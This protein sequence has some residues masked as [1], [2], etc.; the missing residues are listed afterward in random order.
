MQTKNGRFEVGPRLRAGRADVY[1]GR[2]RE[3]GYPVAIKV[4]TGADAPAAFSRES[5]ALR[6]CRHPH[7]ARLLDVTAMPDG[8]ACMVLDWI[9][10]VTLHQWMQSHRRA[11]PAQGAWV[12][13]QVLA[14]LDFLHGA[15]MVLGDLQPSNVMITPGRISGT[16]DGV[17]PRCGLRNRRPGPGETDGSSA[18]RRPGDSGGTAPYRA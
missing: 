7:I 1:S 17:R 11:N 9:D 5:A 3:L 4:P 8:Q 14:A 2:S 18:L 15:G 10:G 13:R 6:V 16:C 12:A